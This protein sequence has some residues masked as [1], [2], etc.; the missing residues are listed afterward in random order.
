MFR[1]QTAVDGLRE[2]AAGRTGELQQEMSTMQDFTFSVKDEWTSYMDKSESHYLEDSAAVESGKHGL[3]EGLQH[4]MAKVRVSAQ[5]WQNAQESLLGLEQRNVASVD[6]IVRSGMEANQ[7][8]CARLSSAASKSLEDV[9]VANMNLLSSIDY[10]LK[11]D[12]DACGNM[13]SMIIPCCG[14]LRDLRGGHYHKIVEIT[15]NAEKCLEVEYVV[16]EPSCSTPRRRSFNLPSMQS[17]EELRTPSFEELLKTFWESRAGKLYANGDVKHHFS[18]VYDA[19]PHSPLRDP[20]DCPV[21]TSCCLKFE[22]SICQ[23][24]GGLGYAY[25]PLQRSKTQEVKR[26]KGT[27]KPANRNIEN[28]VIFIIADGPNL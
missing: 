28:A 22:L 2:T 14:E 16:D 9:D 17:I 20:R 8:L 4:C 5:Q 6:S 15:E 23:P 21:I 19:Q 27:L 7:L 24:V 1:V 18:G 25:T 12:H 3:E 13:D 26:L 10:S 11:L